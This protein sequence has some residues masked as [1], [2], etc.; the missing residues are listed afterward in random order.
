MEEGAKPKRSDDWKQADEAG[1]NR[2]P[3]FEHVE[4]VEQEGASPVQAV[5]G[6]AWNVGVGGNLTRQARRRED[7]GKEQD[8]R[9]GRGEEDVPAVTRQ[10]REA[11]L[12]RRRRRVVVCGRERFGNRPMFGAREDHQSRAEEK[13]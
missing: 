10:K 1:E 8:A 7:D 13:D 12:G 4:I 9:D 2:A 3:H 11:R 6:T 5:E